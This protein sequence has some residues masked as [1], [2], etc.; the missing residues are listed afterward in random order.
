MKLRSRQPRSLGRLDLQGAV[1]RSFL[2][3]AAGGFRALATVGYMFCLIPGLRVLYPDPRQRRMAL[4]RVMGTVHTNPFLSTFLLGYTLRR[5]QNLVRGKRKPP[6]D[7]VPFLQGPLSG[8]GDSLFWGT[9]RPGAAL[10][11]V[12]VAL[13]GWDHPSMVW[14]GP[15]IFLL[16]FNIPHL[17]FRF[18]GMSAGFVYGQRISRAIQGTLYADL[19]RRIHLAGSL[20]IGALAAFLLNQSGWNPEDIFPLCRR[21]TEGP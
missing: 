12:M 14:M 4:S 11:G 19:I 2:I 16:A 7:L 13:F 10:L 8:I 20:V 15:L 17:Y 1:L 5:E 3:Q 21:K 6:E 18:H 9:L